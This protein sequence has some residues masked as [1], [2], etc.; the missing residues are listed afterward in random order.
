MDFLKEH[1]VAWNKDKGLPVPDVGSDKRAT[2]NLARLIDLEIETA[3]LAV[4]EKGG[5][6]TND[7]VW[8]VLE[9][10]VGQ[11][12]TIIKEVTIKKMTYMHQGAEKT[13]SRSTFNS[14]LTKLRKKH[15]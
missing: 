5:R 4:K 3:Y 6:I 8:A 14:V 1:L 7:E 10:R 2:K 13:M 15:A 9:K 12:D 11:Q